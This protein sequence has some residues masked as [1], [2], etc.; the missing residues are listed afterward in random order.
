MLRALR[1]LPCLRGWATSTRTCAHSA[2]TCFERPYGSSSSRRMSAFSTDDWAASTQHNYHH[3]ARC[4][5]LCLHQHGGTSM[6]EEIF[7]PRTAE[8]YRAAPLVEQRERYL[9]HLRETGARRATLRKCANDQLSLMRLLKLKEGD[10]VSADQIEAAAAIWPG[11]KGRRCI[12]AAS[13]QAL[14][15]SF[16]PGIAWFCLFACLPDSH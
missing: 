14:K 6:F 15:P 12:G 9:V 7:F 8:R 1:R 3:G 5:R 4:G 16:S 13:P 11:P 2:S 10:R